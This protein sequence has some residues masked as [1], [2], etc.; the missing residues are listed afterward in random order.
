MTFHR[1]CRSFQSELPANEGQN[2]QIRVAAG[3]ARKNQK[4]SR[5]R[6]A[7]SEHAVGYG[8]AAISPVQETSLGNNGGSPGIEFRAGDEEKSRESSLSFSSQIQ[9]DGGSCGSSCRSSCAS[10]GTSPRGRRSDGCADRRDF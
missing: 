8:A 1:T 10:S 6:C 9:S 3:R 7:H 5:K 2:L 4:G